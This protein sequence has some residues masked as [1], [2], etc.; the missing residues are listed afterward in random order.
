MER[1]M[2]NRFVDKKQLNERPNLCKMGCKRINN[3]RINDKTGK[4]YTTCCSNCANNTEGKKDIV[5][6][7]YCER[8]HF[9]DFR[10][11]I[12]NE[13]V[14]TY[15]NKH[16]LQKMETLNDGDDEAANKKNESGGDQYAVSLPVKEEMIKYIKEE[17][18][19]H[20]SQKIVLSIRHKVIN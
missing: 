11:Q 9:D 1:K 18:K 20:E 15:L 13:A 7:S 16:P 3:T 2:P 12:R 5:H 8:R 19:Y 14:K 10:Y 4:S 17:L 6:E